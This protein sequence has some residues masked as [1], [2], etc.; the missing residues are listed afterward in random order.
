M[1]Q[2][3]MVRRSAI[4]VVPLVPFLNWINKVDSFETLSLSDVQNDSNVYLIPDSDQPITTEELDKEIEK[5]IK[6]HFEGI[7]YNQLS[8]W[9]LD[10]KTF[11]EI[12][13][14][15]FNRWLKVSTHTVIYDM[16]K[17]PIMKHGPIA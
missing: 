11:P 3:Q 10:E 17:K 5:Y 14:E 15:N 8:E 12:T 7:F 9:H 2:Y 16:V 13:Y 6:N 4:V 1:E